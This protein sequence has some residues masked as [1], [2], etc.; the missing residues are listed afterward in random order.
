M[1]HSYKLKGSQPKKMPVAPTTEEPPKAIDRI[2]ALP[3]N[4]NSHK[5]SPEHFLS[6]QRCIVC[7]HVGCVIFPI[8]HEL[9][10]GRLSGDNLLPVCKTHS[11]LSLTQLYIN[12]RK[13][14]RSWLDEHERIDI[15]IDLER[16][17]QQHTK[18]SIWKVK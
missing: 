6:I 18:K 7:N 3:K 9:R 2:F 13:E 14:L 11:K 4:Y 1:D 17:M 5:T 15:T 16:A 8:L 12:H 10:G